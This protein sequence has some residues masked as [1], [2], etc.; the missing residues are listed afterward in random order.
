M[1]QN[2]LTIANAAGGVVR[3]DLNSALQALASLMSGPTAPG[4]TFAFMYWADT[5]DNVLKQRDSANAAWLIRASLDSALVIAK[6]A[7]YT[8]EL[9]DMGKLIE[10]DASGG[11]FTITLP[12]A[13]SATS[14][15]EIS[16]KKTDSS[17]NIITIDG[18]AAET[19]DGDASID[20]GRQLD[21]IVLRSNGSTWYV[22][23][24]HAGKGTPALTDGASV[25]WNA[26]AY[27]VAKLTAA[28]NR[29]IAF[30]TGITVG[31]P[32]TLIHIQDATGGRSPTFAAGWD[33]GA[34]GVPDYS[35]RT[36][37]QKDVITAIYDGTDLM[38]VS[39][40]PW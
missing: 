20:M 37:G 34:A 1:S 22:A 21:S 5:T 6:S 39:S 17:D 40:G 25:N 9:R 12:A 4:T 24:R 23:A 2:D 3:A 26:G 8:V 29:E 10:C 38:A 31:N 13:S 35:T 32:I 19:I 27:P 15:F 7:A 14:G 11:A 28:G 33:F 18:N 30:P 36:N 16:I